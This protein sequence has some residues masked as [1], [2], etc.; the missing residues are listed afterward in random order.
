M[1]V[2]ALLIIFEVVN[3]F[4]KVS[5]FEKTLVVLEPSWVFSLQDPLIVLESYPFK[6]GTEPEPANCFVFRAFERICRFSIFCCLEP[7]IIDLVKIILI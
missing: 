3:S 2:F 4:I 7:E 5:S 1:P 6:E